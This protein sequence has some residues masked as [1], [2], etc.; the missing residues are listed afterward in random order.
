MFKN[1]TGILCY[2]AGETGEGQ[3]GF[4]IKKLMIDEGSRMSE[5]YFIASM[6]MLSVINGSMDISSTPAGKR[7]KDGTEKFLW[8]LGDG[9]SSGSSL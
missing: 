9:H 6:P 3:R 5:E 1:G 2:A 4:T 7:H 8:R